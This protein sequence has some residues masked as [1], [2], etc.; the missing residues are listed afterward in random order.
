MTNL[1]LNFCQFLVKN[2]LSLV[3]TVDILFLVCNNNL[4]KISY[5]G[6]SSKIS[7]IG[8][9]LNLVIK[10]IVIIFQRL[11]YRNYWYQSYLFHVLFKSQKKQTS[12]YLN[13]NFPWKQIMS[14]HLKCIVFSPGENLTLNSTNKILRSIADTIE[15]LNQMCYFFKFRIQTKIIKFIIISFIC[16]YTPNNV[17]IGMHVSIVNNVANPYLGNHRL[18]IEQYFIY[19]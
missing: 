19:L 16:L 3:L 4:K 17:R 10:M 5:S 13:I 9:L 14:L 12:F 8:K 6:D 18:F 1:V 7:I 2:N 15:K 11:I